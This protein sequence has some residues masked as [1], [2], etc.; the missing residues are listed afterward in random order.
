MSLRIQAIERFGHLPGH[1][2]ASASACFLGFGIWATIGAPMAYNIQVGAS[3]FN[4]EHGG[5]MKSD[6]NIA[7]LHWSDV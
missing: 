3:K 1:R 4:D 6:C 7:M 2:C 5:I